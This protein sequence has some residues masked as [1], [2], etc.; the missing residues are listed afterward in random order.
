MRVTIHVR[1]HASATRVGGAHDGH[2][3]VR[4]ATPAEQGKATDAALDA[5]AG[6]LALPRRSVTLASG[7]TSR[8]KIVELAVEPGQEA[9]LAARLGQLRDG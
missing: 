1:P 9:A 2:L 5:L 6:A 4:V 7:A 8:R 3:V